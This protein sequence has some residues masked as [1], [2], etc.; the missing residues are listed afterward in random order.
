VVADFDDW[1]HVPYSLFAV[2]PPA[3]AQVVAVNGYNT[4]GSVVYVCCE[5]SH[6]LV[7][8]A[9]QVEASLLRTARATRLE[10]HPPHW[11]CGAQVS[12][13]TASALSRAQSRKE[14]SSTIQRQLA[15][16]APEPLLA[17]E[18]VLA[19]ADV[20]SHAAPPAFGLVRT[21]VLSSVATV[22]RV[23][24]GF[25]LTK[26]VAVLVGPA[27]LAVVGQFASFT[28]MMAAFA[29][30]GINLGVT[31]YM[32]EYGAREDQRALLLGTAF[33]ITVASS[34]SF[35]FLILLLRWP[36]AEW[37]VGVE[38]VPVLVALAAVLVLFGLNG[39]ALAALN[40][41]KEVRRLV[42]VSITS[43]LVSLVLG[44]ALI[45]MLG[46]RGILY[47]LAVAPA[48]VCLVSVGTVRSRPWFRMSD[49]WRNWEPAV[50]RR[51]G[52]YGVMAATTAVTFPVSH[53][54][55]RNHLAGSLSWEA[56]GYWQGVWQ[57]SEGYLLVAT[58][59]LSMYYLPR[60]SELS[61]KASIRVEILNGYRIIVPATVISAAAIYL[62]RDPIILVLFTPDFLPA[63]ELFA[64][65][66]IG[67]ILKVSAWLLSYLMVAKAMTGLYV[68]TEV[69]FSAAFV[70]LTYL[71]TPQFGLVGVSYAFA[72]NYLFYLLL[73]VWLFRAYL[74]RRA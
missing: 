6:P 2:C 24:S 9:D 11:T 20:Q 21:S 41:A 30:G 71:L 61:D 55:V 51:L 19:P 50:A 67:D 3:S 29:G 40:G 17:S 22:V 27:G 47:A 54:L 38:H 14:V 10:P 28:S 39:L 63:R 58:M 44:A 74:R 5:G 42:A 68:V 32:A 35:A 18:A 52:H 56:A 37:L 70:G 62:L 12:R 25:L 53:I 26:L 36:L 66:L 33:R 4:D 16:A 13:A 34:L 1:Q 72:L 73:M 43:S 57:V 23:G 64:A 45:V 69:V 65:Q 59:S 48:V 7:V 31:K 8:R 49:L 46:L 60:L 15:G